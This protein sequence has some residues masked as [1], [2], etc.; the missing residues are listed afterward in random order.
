MVNQSGVLRGGFSLRYQRSKLAPE[1]RAWFDQHIGV[2]E[3][4]EP[5]AAPDRGGSK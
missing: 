3:Y 4:A 5:G 1:R 2:S